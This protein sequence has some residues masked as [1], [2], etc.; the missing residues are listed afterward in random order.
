MLNE[1]KMSKGNSDNGNVTQDEFVGFFKNNLEGNDKKTVLRWYPYIQKQMKI[2]NKKKEMNNFFASHTDECKEILNVTEINT[3]NS[4]KQRIN[5]LQTNDNWKKFMATENRKNLAELMANINK[6]QPTDYENN[7]K[8]EDEK[9]TFVLEYVYSHLDEI[10][11]KY[12]S[13]NNMTYKTYLLLFLDPIIKTL[14]NELEENKIKI[15]NPW[16]IDVLIGILATTCTGFVWFIFGPAKDKK[17]AENI[18]SEVYESES[19]YGNEGDRDTR[20]DIIAGIFNVLISTL[21][22]CSLIFAWAVAAQA[23]LGIIFAL[24]AVIGIVQVFKYEKDE[25]QLRK[26][27]NEINLKNTEIKNVVDTAQKILSWLN[28]TKPKEEPSKNQETNLNL[29]YNSPDEQQETIPAQQGF[30]TNEDKNKL[31]YE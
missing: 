13:Y 23:I 12:S 30:E 7:N 9:L 31:W 14:N 24:Q 6:I 22:V 8:S 25:F 18:N 20:I 19:K 15:V 10:D 28:Q 1:S 21:F 26:C 27:N 16:Y 11:P 2:N 4:N 5:D 29:E 17:T 3:N